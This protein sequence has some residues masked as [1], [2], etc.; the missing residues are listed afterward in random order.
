MDDKNTQEPRW[1]TKTEHGRTQGWGPP[2]S[3]WVAAVR[4]LSFL[5]SLP[6]FRAHAHTHT[7]THDDGDVSLNASCYYGRWRSC[8]SIF[9]VLFFYSNA[10]RMQLRQEPGKHEWISLWYKK[11]ETCEYILLNILY[12]Y[13]I[14]YIIYTIFYLQ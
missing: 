14:Y 6:S 11:C 13:F 8:I 2:E 4:D 9:L 10:N 5:F 7:H 1:D 12:V 3:P